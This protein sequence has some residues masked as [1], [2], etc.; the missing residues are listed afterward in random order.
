MMKTLTTQRLILRDWEEADFVAFYTLRSDPSVSIPDG[1]RPMRTK[2]ECRPTFAYIREA[3]NNY[4]IVLKAN[5]EVMGSIGLNED[6]EG[7]EDTRNLGFCLLPAY[8]SQGYITE[9][10]QAVISAAAEVTSNLSLL[11]H[12]DHAIIQHLAHKLG[13]TYI[14]TFSN[15]QREC[16]PHPHDELY[17][18]LKLTDGTKRSPL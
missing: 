1:Q 18:T 3:K 12:Q 4:A 7:R 10:L 9:A 13:F 15:I 14:R 17:Y 6:A 16:D 5:G 11:H 8:W 2:E